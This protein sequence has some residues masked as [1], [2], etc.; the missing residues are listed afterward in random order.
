MHSTE[1]LQRTALFDLHQQAGAK[2]VPFAGYEMPVNYVDG[3]IKEHLHTREH[4]GLFDVAHMGQI[5][6]S[7]ANAALLL[8]TLMPVDV[9]SLPLLQQKYGLL[10]NSQGGIIDD[11]MVARIAQDEFMLVVNAAC[12]TNDFAHLTEQLGNRLEVEMLAHKSLLALQGPAAAQVMYRL[13]LDLSDMGFMSVRELQIKGISCWFSRSGYTGEDGFEISV[14]DNHAVE[15]AEMLLADDEVKW[16]G[17]GARDS[18]RMEA[19]LCLYGNDITTQTTPIEGN[20]LWAVSKAR[21]SGG[22]RAGGFP[23]DDIILSQ[24]AARKL[25][26]KPEQGSKLL[27]G[28]A[29][30]GRA[31]IREGAIIEQIE[32]D[33]MGRQI[34]QVTSGGFSPSLGKPICMGYVDIEHSTENNVLNAV[35]RGKR[36]PVNVSKLPF[37][38][39]HYYR[40]TILN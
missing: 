12:K 33:E 22:E 23:G 19:G 5:R 21:R 15:I 1:N 16:V 4:A 34:G 29:P 13:G 11:L 17:L 37:V 39:R 9:V 28:L 32:G 25:G 27:V 26:H 10:L 2:I 30:Q 14:D 35:V 38:A 36:L 40:P 18:L 24:I 20:L 8:E 31:P 3:I 7:G 6:V